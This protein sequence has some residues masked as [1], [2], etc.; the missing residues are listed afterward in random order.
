MVSFCDP[1]LYSVVLDFNHRIERRQVRLTPMRNGGIQLKLKKKT[2]AL[3]SSFSHAGGHAYTH[4]TT[5]SSSSPSSHGGG[6]SG[7]H[8][9]LKKKTTTISHDP[10]TSSRETDSH[11][12]SSTTA[13]SFSSSSSSSS[14]LMT[15]APHVSHSHVER[16]P[17]RTSAASNEQGTLDSLLNP[18]DLARY[19]EELA[20]SMT[21]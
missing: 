7:I 1:S 5:S 12:T 9:T 6:G 16:N 21:K 14:R 4:G 20:K 2:D 3:S 17:N 15:G 11:R 13:S 19:I 18:R 8:F 10:R